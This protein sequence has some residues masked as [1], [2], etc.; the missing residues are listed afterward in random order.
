MGD[1]GPERLIAIH[2][3]KYWTEAFGLHA[4]PDFVDLAW[5]QFAFSARCMQF[6]LK[7]IKCNLAHNCVDHIL[8]L[9]G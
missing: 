3:F 7:V 4:H 1:V 2:K 5:G 6:T 8:N 9:A